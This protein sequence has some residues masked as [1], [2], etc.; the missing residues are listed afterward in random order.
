MGQL[1]YSYYDEFER[2]VLLEK[3]ITKLCD[4]RT[5][6]RRTFPTSLPRTEKP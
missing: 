3:G 4:Q 2:S 6:N 1:V 5:T